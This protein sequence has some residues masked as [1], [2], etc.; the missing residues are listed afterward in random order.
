MAE[1]KYISHVV[2]HGFCWRENRLSEAQD[3]MERRWELKDY[4]MLLEPTSRLRILWEILDMTNKN[5][6]PIYHETLCAKKEN[7]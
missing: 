5:F 7:E 1:T 4:R 3:G 6:K 2:S